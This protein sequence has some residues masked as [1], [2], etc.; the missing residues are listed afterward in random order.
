MAT[1]DVC[2]LPMNGPNRADTCTA[3]VV[4]YPDGT[5]LP[6][7]PHHF[8]EPDGRCHD[9]G[10]KHGGLHHSGCDVE[11][12]PRCHGQLISCGC[13][14]RPMFVIWSIEHTAW[15]R[16]EEMGYSTNVQEAGL[17]P[18]EDTK[19]IL[20]RANRRS[21]NECAIPVEMVGL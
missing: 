7:D 16:P 10:I 19:R 4:E 17:Y 21:F 12:C 2:H 5:V 15:W 18:E 9:C 11:R 6:S 8:E 3:P 1:C 14:A 20:A 13:L